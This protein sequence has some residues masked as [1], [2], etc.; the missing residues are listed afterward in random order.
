MFNYFG[1][2]F[3]GIQAQISKNMEPPAEKYKP[4]G[5]DI[6]AKGNKDQFDF[7]TK[8]S[9][10]IQESQQ[11]ISR[12]NIEDL[13]ANL[14]S[15]ATKINKTK[16]LI[17]LADRLPTGWS[18]VQEYEQDPMARDSDDAQKIRQAEQRAIRKRKVKKSTSFTQSFSSTI[19]KAS[20]FQ[21][22]NA[23]FQNGYSPPVPTKTKFGYNANNPL[24]N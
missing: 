3:E 10:A 24:S 17:K 4:D 5:H 1:K 12:G 16:K 22:W 8:I 13:F 9:F 14:T 20:S 23:S 21:F 11:Q 15:I 2:K 18:V 19:S 6:K 7:P